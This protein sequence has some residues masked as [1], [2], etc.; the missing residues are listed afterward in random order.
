M[1]NT[2]WMNDTT[3]I[4]MWYTEIHS[5]ASTGSYTAVYNPW[6]T[7]PWIPITESSVKCEISFDFRKEKK[8]VT[9][10][11]LEDSDLFKVE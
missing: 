11:L 10:E 4:G 2:N 5:T 9:P 7:I 1:N 8:P 6:Y 3:T